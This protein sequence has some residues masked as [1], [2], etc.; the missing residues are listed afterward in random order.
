MSPW[1]LLTADYWTVWHAGWLWFKDANRQTLVVALEIYSHLWVCLRTR[2][3][4]IRAD[5]LHLEAALPTGSWGGLGSSVGSGFKV[6]LQKCVLTVTTTVS[7]AARVDQV[8]IYFSFLQINQNQAFLSV[9]KRSSSASLVRHKADDFLFP[10]WQ[11]RSQSH[12][13]WPRTGQYKGCD[14]TNYNYWEKGMKQPVY[15]LY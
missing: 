10:P 9:D 4:L 8:S 13:L 3:L 14:M 7:C 15:Y 5:R 1:T 6:T 11:Q 12:D 2:M